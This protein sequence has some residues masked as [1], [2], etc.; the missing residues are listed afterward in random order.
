MIWSIPNLAQK[1]KL[2]KVLVWPSGPVLLLLSS[3]ASV[4]P[5]APL[6]QEPQ[7]VVR[8]FCPLVGHLEVCVCSAKLQILAGRA[9][10]CGTTRSAKALGTLCAAAMCDDRCAEALFLEACTVALQEGAMKVL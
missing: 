7:Q 4:L 1:V 8:S 2:V 6:A 5:L 10:K 9:A 3:A